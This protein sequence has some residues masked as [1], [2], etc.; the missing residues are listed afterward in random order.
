MRKILA[1]TVLGLSMVLASATFALAA[2]TNPA[3][4]PG[5]PTSSPDAYLAAPLTDSLAANGDDAAFDNG[6]INDN[7]TGVG[8]GGPAVDQ[9]VIKSQNMVTT[10]GAA[11]A[12]Q[13]THGEY[14]NNT[15]SC[16]SCHQTHT[17]ASKPLLFKNGVYETC[18]A[19]HDGTLG[20][21]NVFSASSAGTFAGTA[22]GNASMHLPDGAMQVK[23]HLVV[24]DSQPMVQAGLENLPALAAML[25]TVLIVTVYLLTTRMILR[26][27][28]LPMVDYRLL[29]EHQ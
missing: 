7:K 29:G 15:N 22:A 10:P 6:L 11:A 4:D 28:L 21:Y 20:F 3:A 13:R 24:I 26:T 8:V 5:D 14:Q 23:Q 25:L 12:T 18:T 1:T 17:A 9:S 27:H 16:A 2:S 19:C